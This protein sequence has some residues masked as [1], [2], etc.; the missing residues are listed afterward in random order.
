MF[1][2][3]LLVLVVAMSAGCLKDK[4]P[5]KPACSIDGRGR[6]VCRYTNQNG[7]D[8][9]VCSTV[10]VWRIRSL[11]H[12][13]PLV[14]CSGMIEGYST[15]EVTFTIGSLDRLCRNDFG[16]WHEVCGLLV[17]PNMTKLTNDMLNELAR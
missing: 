17:D 16:D 3:V 7:G 15:R 9:S 12:T 10:V 5:I 14:V 2:R 4:I 8:E 13:E 1:R 11:N 6:G